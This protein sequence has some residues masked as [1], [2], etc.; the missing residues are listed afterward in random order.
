[1]TLEWYLTFSSYLGKGIL[2]L[3]EGL[4]MFVATNVNVNV[5]IRET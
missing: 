1:M 2:N 3:L 5:S 4:N